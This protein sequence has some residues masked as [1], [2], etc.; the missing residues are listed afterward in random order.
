MKCVFFETI[1]E[2][3]RIDEIYFEANFTRYDYR[4]YSNSYGDSHKFLYFGFDEEPYVLAVDDGG[5][6]V[7]YE[8]RI[9]CA[10]LAI[11]WAKRELSEWV[12]DCDEPEVQCS[13]TCY[14]YQPDNDE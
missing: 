5:E 11:E 7:D 14:I 4:G 12:I 9:E 6:E 10:K 3:R 13:I 1:R 8:R 2:A